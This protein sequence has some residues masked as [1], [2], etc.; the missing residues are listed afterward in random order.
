MNNIDYLK[1]Q[2]STLINLYN[3]KRHND[4]VQK[5][6]ILI[7]KFPNQIIF[8]NA[9]SLSLSALENNK[10]A[11]KLLKEALNLQP[12][13][14]HVL[15]NLGLVNE[16]IKE[17]HIAKEYYQKALSINDK[18]IDALVNLGNLELLEKNLSNAKN[19]YEKALQLSTSK[20]TNEII[21][22]ALGNY[23]QQV[24]NFTD[25][26]ENFQTI[27]KLNPNNT[28][29]DKSISLIHTYKDSKDS[30]LKLMEKKLDF[31]L[32][33]EGKQKLY[34]AL[35]KAYEDIK[36]YKKSFLFSEKANFI[37]NKAFKYDLKEDINLFEQIR[38]LFK[39][40]INK[41]KFKTSNKII[42]IVGM[43]RSGT[44][45]VEQILSSHK[46]VYGAGE[47][48][49]LGESINKNLFNDKKFI[50][51]KFD[52][53]DYDI[54]NKIQNEYID[55]IKSFNYK[56]K[57]I[58]DKAPLNFKW[59]GFIRN[60][61]P[62]SKII[63]CQRDPMDV[64]Y[65]NF[66]NSFQSYSLSFCYD[67]KNLGTFYNLYKK[68]MLFWNETYPDGIYNLSYEKIINDQENETKS[69]LKFCN[70]EWDKNCLKPHENTKSVATA[71]LAQV[72]SPIYKSSIK[73][74]ENYAEELKELK[75]ILSKG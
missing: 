25:A 22:M 17:T 4:V 42:F 10:E 59:I 9:T 68:L 52:E 58:T 21:N 67:I 34:F 15:N 69:L 43:P 48:S 13:N 74:W 44:S 62:N 28:S 23:N 47:L 1:S 50:K 18:F 38:E 33:D 66:K 2:V 72:R 54:L 35:G 12:N 26:I 20:E 63:H 65:S 73:K 56:E 24:G 55:K 71:S 39:N 41:S 16:R 31:N 75:D 8:Y 64:C 37:A 5:G 51:D 19:L 49:F 40:K 45:L 36:N 60:L 70:L 46:D 57:F 27:N 11:L 3:A 7:K 32:D 53:I 30:H 61:F 29:A 14:I 6:K